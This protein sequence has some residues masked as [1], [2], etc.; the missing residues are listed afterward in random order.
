MPIFVSSSLPTSTLL[1]PEDPWSKD[2]YNL[3]YIIMCLYITLPT[4]VT[5]YS[6]HCHSFTP[7]ISTDNKDACMYLFLQK[8]S[9]CAI[10]QV[11]LF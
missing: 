3:Q 10:C 5:C 4:I 2:G 6:H 11:L 9:F 8:K 1:R 7:Q